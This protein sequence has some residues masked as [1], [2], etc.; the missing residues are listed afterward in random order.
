MMNWRCSSNMNSNG[1]CKHKFVNVL[2]FR[3]VNGERYFEKGAIC[4]ECLQEVLELDDKDVR[5]N[6][7]TL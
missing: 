7:L 3:D 6:I 1:D 4:S 5:P 2:F